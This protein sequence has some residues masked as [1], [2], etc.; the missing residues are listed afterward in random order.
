M[1]DDPPHD[2]R[3]HPAA[4]PLSMVR[5][6]ESAELVEVGAGLQF[7]K[8]L[9]DLGLGPGMVVRVVQNN[10][11]GPLILAIKDDTRL[12]I[13]RGMAHRIRVVLRESG[14][15]GTADLPAAGERHHRRRAHERRGM[16]HRRRGSHDPA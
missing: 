10:V 5:P 8:R 6:G 4:L 7:R 3:H 13:G 11:P 16:F 14:V 12:A 1:H 15:A 2:E 9:A